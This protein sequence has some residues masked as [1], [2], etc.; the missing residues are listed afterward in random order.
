MKKLLIMLFLFFSL[1][2]EAMSKHKSPSYVDLAYRAQDNIAKM[3]CEKHNL[4][5]SGDYMALFDRVNE[6]GLNFDVK[7]PLSKDELRYL[8]IDCIHIYLYFIN[9][10]QEIRPYLKNYPFTPENLELIIYIHGVNKEDISVAST[11]IGKLFY[12]FYDPETQLKDRTEVETYEE[13]LAIVKQ[14]YP[15]FVDRCEEK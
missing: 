7:G 9:Q 13:A 6:L 15:K 5:V 11:Y 3:I 14:Q 8:L 2:G 4:T 10:D 1:Y 12:D